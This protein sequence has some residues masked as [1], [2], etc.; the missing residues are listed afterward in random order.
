MERKE[1][2][3]KY[4][5]ACER[6]RNAKKE[7]ND[8]CN[9]YISELHVKVDDCVRISA[10]RFNVVDGYIQSMDYENANLIV[11]LNPITKDGKRGKNVRVISVGNPETE[12]IVLND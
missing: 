8:L 11:R 3:T 12:I 1:F 4:N 7:R 9:K 5:A 10:M 6:V 2:I